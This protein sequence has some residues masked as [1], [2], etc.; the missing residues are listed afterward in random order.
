MTTPQT[1]I[2]C[3][4]A[5]VTVL[6][7]LLL[8]TWAA[9]LPASGGPMHAPVVLARW[10]PP[11]TVRND[12]R[13]PAPAAVSRARSRSV[14]PQPQPQPQPSSAGPDAQAQTT[15]EAAQPGG[16]SLE[17]AL[18]VDGIQRAARELSRRRGLA[19]LS[20][21]MLGQ[22]AVDAQAA[23]RAGVAS[24][25]RSDCLKAGEGGYAH[26]GLGLFALPVL[27]FDAATGGCRK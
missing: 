7:G 20:D 24:A 17:P 23:L 15:V 18:R 6:H 11:P 21:D 8:W 14:R 22:H 2:A 19:E 5:G 1:R 27:V 12:D 13:S 25:A 16:A 4:A 3:L 9:H 26:S 10:L